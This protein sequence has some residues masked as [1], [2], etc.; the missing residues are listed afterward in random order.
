VYDFDRLAKL[1]YVEEETGFLNRLH[2]HF[3]LWNIENKSCTS[4]SAISLFI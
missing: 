3:M 2:T 1:S 4:E